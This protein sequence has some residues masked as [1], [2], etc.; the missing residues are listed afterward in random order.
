LHVCEPA[1]QMPIPAVPA[2]P[3][4]QLATAFGAQTQPAPPS[5]V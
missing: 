3:D 5:F 1:L 4:Y 2:G